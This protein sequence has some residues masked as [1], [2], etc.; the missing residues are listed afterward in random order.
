MNTATP[1]LPT[2]NPMIRTKLYTA[3]RACIARLF[4]DSCR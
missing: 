4:L 1:K 3:I 2:E